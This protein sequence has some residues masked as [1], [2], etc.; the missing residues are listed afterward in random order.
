MTTTAVKDFYQEIFGTLCSELNLFLD[1]HSTHD[2]GHFNVFNIADMY[3]KKTT[4]MPYNRRTYYKISLVKGRNR[5][6]Y[7]DKVLEIEEYGVLFATPKIPY[8]YI[9]ADKNQAGHFCV[10]TPDFIP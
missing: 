1:D 10:F 8:R 4:L 7:A 2:I 5:V 6:E 3:C 9:P